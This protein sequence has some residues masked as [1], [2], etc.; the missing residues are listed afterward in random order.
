M[1]E[2]SFETSWTYRPNGTQFENGHE[3]GTDCCRPSLEILL[4][5]SRDFA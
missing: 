4:Y 5:R 3:D 1:L 2:R